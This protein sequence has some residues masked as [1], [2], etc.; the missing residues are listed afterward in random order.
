MYVYVI[1][2]THLRCII[3]TLDV[4]YPRKELLQSR[5]VR[6]T[7]RRVQCTNLLK[8]DDLNYETTVVELKNGKIL[9]PG[10]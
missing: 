10:M 1:R 8:E 6:W 2:T 9:F 3:S 7:R 5:P 4:R